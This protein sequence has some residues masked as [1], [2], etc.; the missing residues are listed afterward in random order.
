MADKEKKALDSE[1]K[2]KKAVKAKKKGKLKNAWL[3]FKREF[4]NISWP[5]AKQVRK[6]SWVV[7]V[8][9][10]FCAVIIGALDLAFQQGMLTLTG[11]FS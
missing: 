1:N 6:N 3:G 4:K 2:P 10:A 8:T 5:S 11:L 7:L 9:V